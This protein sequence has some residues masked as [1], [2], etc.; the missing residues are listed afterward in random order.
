MYCVV[1]VHAIGQ[2]LNSPTQ[3][4]KGCIEHR[5]KLYREL[6]DELKATKKKNE[7]QITEL[8]VVFDHK[9]AVLDK[10]FAKKEQ[11]NLT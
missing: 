11:V 1:E 3:E 8:K 2:L 6:E 7:S 10:S 9:I 5:K 4:M